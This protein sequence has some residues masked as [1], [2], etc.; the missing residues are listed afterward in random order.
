IGHV[1]KDL[2]EDGYTVGGTVTFASLTARNLGQRTAVLTSAS[3]DLNLSP[4]YQGIEVLR[5][6]SPVT[7]TFQNLYSTNG[8]RTQ[9]LRAV[10]NPVKAEDVPPAWREAKIVLLGPLTNEMDGSIARAFPHSLIGVTPQGW[11]RHW[12]GDG[13]VF[14]KPWENAAEV[15]DYARM[16][17]FSENDVERD[18]QVIQTYARM[19]D[20]L[21]VTKGARG[22]TVYHRGE[23]RHFPAFETVEVDPTGA[24]DVF[25]AA[26]LIELERS[27]DPYAAAHFAN[28][29]AS[30]V[31]EKPGTEGIPTLEQVEK[32]LASS[33]FVH[34]GSNPRVHESTSP[35]IYEPTKKEVN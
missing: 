30:F 23:V 25:A 33:G 1:T 17:V 27:G 34:S 11:M 31:V 4:V 12:D 19:A 10:A 2:Q 5:L 24:G 21:V 8:T 7:S 35:R 9:Y 13:R 32:R 28:C 16:V 3:P 15:L 26:Y 18:E 6:P 29:V 20:I 22:A 14:P